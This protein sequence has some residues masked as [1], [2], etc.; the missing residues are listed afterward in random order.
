MI[1]K[2]KLQQE[3]T[4]Y[5]S[6]ESKETSKFK[7]YPRSLSRL[8]HLIVDWLIINFIW[9]YAFAFATWY[10]SYRGRHD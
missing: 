3:L 7:K 6:R 2:E 9:P 1:D 4:A 8:I 5:Q 10:F